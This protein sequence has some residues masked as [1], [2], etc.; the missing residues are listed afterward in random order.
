M[1]FVTP[2][3]RAYSAIFQNPLMLL[4]TALSAL[5]LYN[6]VRRIAQVR[7]R[8]QAW[9]AE[10]LQPWKQQLGEDIAFYIAVPIGVLLH[11]LGHA[12]VV[13]AYGGRVVEF[14][15]FFFWGYVLPDRV[16]PTDWQEWVLSS[17]GT[18]ANLLFALVIWLWGRGQTSGPLRFAALRSVRFQIY[19]ALIYYPLFTLFLAIG[20]WRTIYDFAATPLLSAGTAVVHVAILLAFYWLDRRGYFELPAFADVADQQRYAAL[21]RAGGVAAT[22]TRARLALRGNAPRTA[23]REIDAALRDAP[24]SA[25]A[26]FLWAAAHTDSPERVPERAVKHARQALTLGLSD[27][28]MRASAL[29][30]IGL[31]DLGRGRAAEALAHFDEAIAAATAAAQADRPVANMHVL[32]DARSQVLLRLNRDV[33]AERD[34]NMALQLAQMHQQPAAAAH[35]QGELEALRLRARR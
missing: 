16:F 34:L 8:T 10:P 18:W 26:H 27:A 11:E 32:Y 35:Y 15:F 28:G 19:F 12:L 23:R 13:W 7:G 14:G 24:D 30:M 1:D 17:A 33:E 22:L 20:D 9:R 25:E 3:V 4:F 5:Q 31:H 21:A 29:H 6:G 2:V